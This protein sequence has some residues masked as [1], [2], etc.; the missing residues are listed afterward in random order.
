M[1]R[2]LLARRIERHLAERAGLDVVV[3]EDE[4]T[5]VL[6]GRVATWA[7]RQAAEEL[8]EEAA[9]GR[10]VENQLEVELTLAEGVGTPGPPPGIMSDEDWAPPPATGGPL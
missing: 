8:A 4:A 9:D 3:H 5:I 7:E 1:E 10:R 2:T 6:A